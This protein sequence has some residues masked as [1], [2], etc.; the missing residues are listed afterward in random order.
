M[1]NNAKSTPKGNKQGR[2]QKVRKVVKDNLVSLA[3]AG[4]KGVVQQGAANLIKAITRINNKQ[5][6]VK[7]V[8]IKPARNINRP[9]GAR[10]NKDI[11]TYA[12][13]GS[14]AKFAELH[15]SWSDFY[16]SYMWKETINNSYQ[17][18]RLRLK[19]NLP[20]T[21]NKLAAY[22]YNAIQ[23]AVMLKQIERDIHWYNYSDPSTPNFQEM[24]ITRATTFGTYGVVPTN[25]DVAF[26]TAWADT[27]SSYE[28]LVHAVKTNVRV[29]PSLAL[30]ISHYFGSVFTMQN[31]GYNDTYLILRMVEQKWATYN[32]DSDTITYTPINP[33]AMTV[34][35]ITNLITGLGSEYGIV[36]ADLVNSEQYTP[37]VLDSLN[38]YSYDLIWDPSLM[39]AIRNG[40]TSSSAVTD[41]GYVRIDQSP[42]VAD[43]LTQYIFMGAL[44]R[45]MGTTDLSNVSAIRIVSMC[46]KYDSDADLTWT[47][48]FSQMIV[49]ETGD[50]NLQTAFNGIFAV[51]FT[52]DVLEQVRIQNTSSASGSNGTI[53][54]YGRN[55]VITWAN[56]RQ[57][58]ISLVFEE[59]TE[60][61]SQ[62]E[63]PL[64][65]ADPATTQYLYIRVGQIDKIQGSGSNNSASIFEAYSVTFP[66]SI[67][68]G[69]ELTLNKFSYQ[70]T[71]LIQDTALASLKASSNT[72][73]VSTSGDVI[74]TSTVYTS[75]SFT[76][77]TT[78]GT[79]ANNA[80][81]PYVLAT[82]V[83]AGVLYTYSATLTVATTNNSGYVNQVTDYII[84]YIT[85]WTGIQFSGVSNI[86]QGTSDVR[87]IYTT[88]AGEIPTT[89]FIQSMN[90]GYLG[91]T[92][93]IVQDLN[94]F[95]PIFPK[96]EVENTITV[97]STTGSST[98]TLSTAVLSMPLV[99]KEH[100]PY[101]YNVHDLKPT[102]YN[103]FL[104]LFT[105]T[106]NIYQLLTM[107]KGGSQKK[108]NSH[109]SSDKSKSDKE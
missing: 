54:Y 21:A 66:S 24:F 37:I 70:R 69:T 109:R 93:A 22:E 91:L 107:R 67:S 51:E 80:F 45:D 41:D 38:E 19:S 75:N 105:P 76:Q 31:D 15:T 32:A 34:D 74:L 78:T 17:L 16:A 90:I 71:V 85:G 4:L 43:D 103:M 48:A 82:Y 44:Q 26:S 10:F 95:I 11:T 73:Y 13:N 25:V 8:D 61:L 42:D 96:V 92:L 97:R 57:L 65:S 77:V 30:F 98:S 101:W 99:K 1:G 94:A 108:D 52:T 106:D 84:P 12:S 18:L 63:I 2:A 81:S 7:Y 47:S 50:S 33:T 87:F 40:Y 100:I 68:G 72:S 5:W 14:V 20:Y 3:K 102:I 46:I 28:R 86:L 39:Q 27:V 79:P 23:A 64:H 56:T 29:A 55:D 58:T 9:M 49:S 83:K 104:S 36:V 53:T 6:Y 35:Q 88:V 89:T 59:D 62:V 60:I